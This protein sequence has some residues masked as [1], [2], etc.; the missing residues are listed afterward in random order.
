MNKT[1]NWIKSLGGIFIEETISC[2]IG[3]VH[4]ILGF[5]QSINALVMA[6]EAFDSE[7]AA[8]NASVLQAMID[9]ADLDERLSQLEINGIEYDIDDNHIDGQ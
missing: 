8:L 1:C 2:L 6:D 7:L 4:V 9:I 3:K 5:T